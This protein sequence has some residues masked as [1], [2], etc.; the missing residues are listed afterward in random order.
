MTTPDLK[1]VALGTRNKGE[2]KE[3]TKVGAPWK[4]YAVSHVS[5]AGE[6]MGPY[7]RVKGFDRDDVPV[8]ENLAEGTPEYKRVEKWVARG[9]W[10]GVHKTNGYRRLFACKGASGRVSK[11]TALDIMKNY[12]A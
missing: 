7:Y 8:L 11:D 2:R 9:D 1:Y 6:G 5:D 12:I 3:K 4:I 10:D